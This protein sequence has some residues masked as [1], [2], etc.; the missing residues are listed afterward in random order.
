MDRDATSVV[1]IQPLGPKIAQRFV[2]GGVVH[3]RA[4]A[5]TQKELVDV[6]RLCAR[7]PVDAP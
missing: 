5:R 4:Q 1:A 7:K 2:I 6:G 3:L